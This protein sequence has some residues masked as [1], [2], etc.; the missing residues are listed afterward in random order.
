MKPNR[1]QW[2]RSWTQKNINENDQVKCR[3]L[4]SYNWKWSTNQ[5]KTNAHA[6][7]FTMVYLWWIASY[8]T[9][10]TIDDL[11]SF[12]G[13]RGSRKIII[14]GISALIPAKTRKHNQQWLPNSE[15]SCAILNKFDQPLQ[16]DPRLLFL[17]GKNW[18]EVIM[19]I[20]WE[21]RIHRYSSHFWLIMPIVHKLNR[22]MGWRR[23]LQWKTN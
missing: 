11:K 8:L 19:Q 5:W 13:L 2:K 22:K 23:W 6:N 1:Q 3:N 4:S 12:H 9:F 21:I 7:R 16:E 15:K 17:V 14:T 10:Q 18:E 20:G